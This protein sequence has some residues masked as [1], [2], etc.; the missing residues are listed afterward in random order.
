MEPVRHDELPGLLSRFDVGLALE[1]RLPA[2]RDLTI[3]N[4]I[5]QYLNAGLAI[6]AT[7]TQGQLEVLEAAGG[8]GVAIDFS[9]DDAY[10]ALSS[11][12]SDAA[13]L[14][15]AQTASRRAAETRFCWEKEE[16]VL[17]SLVQ[18]AIGKAQ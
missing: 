1:P 13:R 10:S 14:R 18:M 5:L 3:T 11:F 12:L 8:A 17:G 16:P 15:S 2:N 9:R 6:V 4:K 7:P